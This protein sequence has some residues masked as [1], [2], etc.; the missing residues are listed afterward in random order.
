MKKGYVP[1]KPAEG[2][3]NK[4]GR[5]HTFACVHPGFSN[6]KQKTVNQSETWLRTGFCKINKNPFNV[7][8]VLL[9]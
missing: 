6:H 1:D 5:L 7:H 2:K 3:D 4:G 8:T 9:S